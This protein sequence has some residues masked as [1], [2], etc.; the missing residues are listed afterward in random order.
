MEDFLASLLGMLFEL[1]LEVFGEALLGFGGEISISL[2]V[3]SSKRLL[4]F[5]LKLPRLSAAIY[6]AATGISMG[7]LSVLLFPHQLFHPSRFHGLSL[8]LSPTVTGLVMA[9]IG[10]GLRKRGKRPIQIESFGF[11]FLFA[12]VAALIRFL[13]L[14]LP[15]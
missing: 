5:V 3:R 15:R 10:K 7:A 8:L 4:S 14:F 11:G 13:W 9:L 1:L 6:V 2:L 12:F